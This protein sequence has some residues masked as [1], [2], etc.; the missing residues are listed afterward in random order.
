MQIPRRSHILARMSKSARTARPFAAAE[1][2]LC[3]RDPILARIVADIGPCGLVP[4]K[5]YF[6]TLC[7]SIVSQ[8]L[9]VKAAATIFGRFRD[10][11]PRRMPTPAAVLATSEAKL[12]GAGLSTQKLGYMR[13]LAGKYADGTIP[14]R[15]LGRMS[16]EEVAAALTQV[17]GIGVWTAQMFLIF[18]LNRPDVWP[19]DDLGI[20]KAIQVNWELP[21]MPV[22]GHLQEIA[23]PW[24]PY[25][26]VA[27]W[28]LWAS[29]DNKPM[30]NSRNRGSR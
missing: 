15:R 2:A 7:E 25:R 14:A 10:L 4:R 13:D 20:R 17:K 19:T 23:E 11:F 3:R 5:R 27:A 12:R 26:S 1:R 30:K 29:L 22:D 28:Y 18:V 6:M 16:D 8:Q 9:A 21:E 24:R